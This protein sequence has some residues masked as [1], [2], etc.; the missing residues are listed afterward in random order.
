M[1]FSRAGYIA[2]K[3]NRN[4]TCEEYS[5]EDPITCWSPRCRGHIDEVWVIYF[6][7]R[8]TGGMLT[9]K[10]PHL[11]QMSRIRKRNRD[12]LKIIPD[13]YSATCMD[14]PH[15]D[16]CLYPKAIAGMHCLAGF[17]NVL[18]YNINELIFCLATVGLGAGHSCWN[19]QSSPA[20]ISTRCKKF[21]NT[22]WHQ[23]EF[24]RHHALNQ[25]DN[26]IF[27]ASLLINSCRN[28]GF[29]MQ[30]FALRV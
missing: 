1:N 3:K 21:E 16:C 2:R 17:F 15:E 8:F 18:R 29:L 26:F 30:G 5:G 14:L 22:A 24:A 28:C 25:H 6:K 7:Q 4:F 20:L 10:W 11:R 12:F 9:K 27:Y 19:T 23:F 13:D